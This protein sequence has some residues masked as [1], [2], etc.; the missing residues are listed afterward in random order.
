MV[1]LQV[2]LPYTLARRDK[3]RRLQIPKIVPQTTRSLSVTRDFKNLVQFRKQIWR[4]ANENLRTLL[5]EKE[6]VSA[7][8]TRLYEAEAAKEIT[9][10][11]RE[12]PGREIQ[13][14]A[15]IAR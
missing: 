13:N 1:P 6:L 3:M 2:L 15:E 10:D 8:L 12:I 9:K 14:R 7:A 5:L 11:E 4:R